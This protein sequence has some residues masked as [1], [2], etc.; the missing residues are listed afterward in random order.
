[1]DLKG[2]L[3]YT[4]EH[5]WARIEGDTAV[6]GITD[7]A[8][9][10]LGDIVFI[11]LPQEGDE[12]TQGEPFGSIES[13]KAVSDLHAPLSGEIIKVNEALEDAPEIIN[14]DPYGEGWIIEIKLADTNEIKNLLDADKYQELVDQEA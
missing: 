5:T 4:R 13:V 8:Q 2:D 12:T 10:E 6:I 7:Y 3:Y 1:M 14:E 11:D 9:S